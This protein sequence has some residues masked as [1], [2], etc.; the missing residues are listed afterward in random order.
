D[1]IRLEKVVDREAVLAREI[2]SA[3]AEGEARDTGGRD[4][5]KGHGQPERV[6][7]VIDVA[8][9]AASIHPNGSRCRI[10]AYTFHHREVNHQSVGAAAEPGAVVAAAGDRDEEI[11]VAAEVHRGDDVG[12]VHAARNQ[13][14]PLVDHA[15]VKSTGSVIVS[16]TWT[17][18][19]S[20]K[21]L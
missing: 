20:A 3:P 13:P 16:I 2:P 15:V 4:D 7:G 10:H 11:L 18:G 5:A 9:R 1:N 19:S 8:R 14:Q 17:D 12:D 6:R 21:V